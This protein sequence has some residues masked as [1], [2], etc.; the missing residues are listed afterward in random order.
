MTMQ[1]YDF[2]CALGDDCATATYL[3]MHGLR[4]MSLPLD[5][6]GWA[7]TGLDCYVD[8]VCSDFRDFMRLDHLE[9]IG[10]SPQFQDKAHDCYRDRTTGLTIAHDF[11]AGVPL[12][13]SYEEVKAKYDRRIA[14]FY[15]TM[16]H[17]KRVLFVYQTKVRTIDKDAIV[18]A[19][20]RLRAKFSNDAI[21][22]LA[23]SNDPSAPHPV[24]M[25]VGSGAYH[26]KGW[27]YDP[28]GDRYLGRQQVY[29]EIFSAIRL[30]SGIKRLIFGTILRI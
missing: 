17:V 28:D 19:V 2:V 8:Y 7:R 22:V 23:V 18:S 26:A 12:A 20:T 5:W 4:R 3:R 6:V 13:E 24:F 25:Q 11:P 21:D 29:D 10:M 1:R 15:K 30:R 14:R 27:I 9:Q 16:R